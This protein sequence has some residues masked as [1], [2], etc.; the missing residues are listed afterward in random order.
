MFKKRKD[1][2]NKI[3]PTGKK[4]KVFIT[5]T[6]LVSLLFGNARSSSSRQSSPNFDNQTIHERVIND[7]EFN[8]FENNGQ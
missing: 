7:Q 3:K 2:Q 6:L 4:R 1:N 5:I 8:S